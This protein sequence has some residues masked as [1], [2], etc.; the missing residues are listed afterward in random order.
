M[1]RSRELCSFCWQQTCMIQPV[2][3]ACGCCSSC[4]PRAIVFKLAGHYQSTRRAR[5]SLSLNSPPRSI[6]QQLS[7]NI[8]TRTHALVFEQPFHFIVLP[9]QTTTLTNPSSREQFWALAETGLNVQCHERK[10]KTSP[11]RLCTLFCSLYS[12][13]SFSSIFPHCT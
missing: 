2:R 3:E 5:T 8:Q 12:F 4:P 1:H 11:K 7:K 13:I 6:H 9:H 10:P